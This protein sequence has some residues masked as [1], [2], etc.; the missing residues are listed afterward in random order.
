MLMLCIFRLQLSGFCHDV[1]GH[2]DK[3]LAKPEKSSGTDLGR[4]DV[5]NVLLG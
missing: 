5:R 2:Y 1:F 4:H 3:P